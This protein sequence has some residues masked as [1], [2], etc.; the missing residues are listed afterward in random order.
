MKTNGR[1]GFSIPEILISIFIMSFLVYQAIPYKQAADFRESID[2]MSTD[3]ESLANLGIFN[4]YTGYATDTGGD[5]SSSF[6]VANITAQRVKDCTTT[7]SFYTELTGTN[8]P[9]IPEDSYFKMLRNNGTGCKIFLNDI[10]S[11]TVRLFIDCSGITYG[12]KQYIEEVT[13]ANTKRKLSAVFF[14]SN[15]VAKDLND[16]ENGTKIDGLFSIDLKK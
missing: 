4:N 2:N 9:N 15:T 12:E 11:F 16:D 6:D 3:I 1:N 8:D 5:C 13:I 14:S 7:Q 10:D